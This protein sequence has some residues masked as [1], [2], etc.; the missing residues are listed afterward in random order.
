MEFH[1]G[2]SQ[3]A[4]RDFPYSRSACDIDDSI[5]YLEVPR[6]DDD[7]RFTK[8]FAVGDAEAHEFFHHY[9]FVVF[10]DLLTPQEAASSRADIW[11][12]IESQTPGL[13]RDNSAT[14]P[15]WQ[16]KQFGMPGRDSSALWRPQLVRNRC[17]PNVAAAFASLLDCAPADLRANHDRWVVYRPGF[18]SRAQI[19]LDVNPW[20]YSANDER[21]AARLSQLPYED[22]EDLFRGE[23]HYITAETGPHL[24]GVLNLADNEA[25]DGG[26]QCV[27]G[28]HHYYDKW[29]RALGPEPRAAERLYQ[30]G[31]PEHSSL[32]RLAQRVPVREGS[33]ILWD[34]R[35]VHGSAPN[36]GTAN[37]RMA[38]FLCLRSAKL[39][40][41]KRAARRAALVARVL[42]D[43]G[44]DEPTSSEQRQVLGLK[45]A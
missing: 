15:L 38:Q 22:Y 33:L 18:A 4:G 2:E 14:W 5:P 12:Y 27:P 21:V 28:F 26:F 24:Q 17:H 23:N 41:Q 20:Q 29:L 8:S 16:S 9:G 31:F 3:V 10:R 25:E 13:S 45:T 32:Y 1:V 39:W 7:W 42:R 35:V 34:V 44:I 30:F 40:G 36:R 19:H 43:H 37:P 11:S 6:D